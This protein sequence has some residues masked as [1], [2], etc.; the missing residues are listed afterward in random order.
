MIIFGQPFFIGYSRWAR[1]RLKSFWE[2]GKISK[3]NDTNSANS[4]KRILRVRQSVKYLTLHHGRIPYLGGHSG[5]IKVA[6]RQP[7]QSARPQ[8]HDRDQNHRVNDRF[9]LPGYPQQFRDQRHAKGTQ[10]RSQTPPAPSAIT[11]TR[12]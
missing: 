9:Q 12:Q 10:G 8:E 11:N 4:V 2:R 6:V 7:D 5:P 1:V 3:S